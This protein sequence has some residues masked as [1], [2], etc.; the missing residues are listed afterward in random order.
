M[1]TLAYVLGFII[2]GFVLAVLFGRAA[3]LGVE[4]ESPPPRLVAEQL[5]D[6]MDALTATQAA[7]MVEMIAELQER[8]A[9]NRKI[10]AEL[11]TVPTSP[12]VIR[13]RAMVHGDIMDDQRALYALRN[14][15]E[16]SSAVNAACLWEGRM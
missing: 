1:P 6:R 15:G 11:Y 10:L 4:Q 12:E 8:L 16:Y 9:D 7:L 13:H 3:R 5:A 14:P 2:F